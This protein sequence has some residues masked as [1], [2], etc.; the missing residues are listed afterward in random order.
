EHRPVSAA[1]TKSTC[2][3]PANASVA[4]SETGRPRHKAWASETPGAYAR[5]P[6]HQG[7]LQGPAPPTPLQDPP[8]P[9]TWKHWS[10]ARPLHAGA[11]PAVAVE[12]CQPGAGWRSG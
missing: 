12:G 7:A 5:P 2:A 4:A 3:S 11:G 6:R 8:V 10:P 9:S 1:T